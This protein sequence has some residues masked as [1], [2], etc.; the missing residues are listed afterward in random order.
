V[1]TNVDSA[2]TST[3]DRSPVRGPIPNYPPMMNAIAK[4]KPSPA[5]NSCHDMP[6][7]LQARRPRI[8]EQLMFRQAVTA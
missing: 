7:L 3:A 6:L 8:T 5:R 4:I 1:S 2:T